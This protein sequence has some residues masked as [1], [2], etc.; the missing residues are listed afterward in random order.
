[1]TYRS[2]IMLHLSFM[3]K[4]LQRIQNKV[5]KIIYNLPTLYPTVLQQNTSICKTIL[6][7]CEVHEY[8]VLKYIIRVLHYVGH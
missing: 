4:C 5:L 6:P 1:M 3:L 7:I 2:L 8:Q